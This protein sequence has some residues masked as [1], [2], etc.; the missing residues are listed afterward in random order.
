[1]DSLRL[2]PESS[3][4]RPDE[5]IQGILV[6]IAHRVFFLCVILDGGCPFLPCFRQLCLEGYGV[7]M[8]ER[9]DVTLLEYKAVEPCPLLLAVR[10]EH[11]MHCGLDIGNLCQ[12]PA[13]YILSK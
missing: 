6:D 7:V 13:A 9:V 3:L 5:I 10:L 4:Y 11:V 12:Y 1:M 8:C 2:S